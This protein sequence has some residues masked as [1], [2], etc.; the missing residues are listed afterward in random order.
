M[1][2]ECGGRPTRVVPRIFCKDA[3]GTRTKGGQASDFDP[4]ADP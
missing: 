2:L 1:G 3:D 4:E